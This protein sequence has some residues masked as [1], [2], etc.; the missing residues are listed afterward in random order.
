VL[1]ELIRVLPTAVLVGVVP[2]YFWAKCLS[3]S[4]DHAERI[5]YSA[6]LSMTLVPTAALLQAH[7]FGTGVT[8]FI[9]AVSMAVVFA[10]GFAI[11]L[12]LGPASYADGP[13]FDPP[14][15]PPGTLAL[16][17]LLAA[18][19]VML[20]VRLGLVPEGRFV[21]LVA[22]LFAGIFALLVSRRP[23]AQQR[24]RSSSGIRWPLAC[25]AL[26]LAVFLTVLVRAYLGPVLHDWP[27]IRGGD[28]YS[29]A[30]MANLMMTEGTTE[31][32]LIYPPGFH[33]LTALVSRSSGLEPLRIFPVL[34]PALTVLPTL[35]CYV[36]ARRLWGRGHGVVAAFFSGVLLVGP[37]ASFAEARYPNLVSADFLIAMAAAALIGVYVSPGARP[38][39]L[40]AVLGSSVVLY[41]QVASLYLAL[42]LAVI[43]ALFLP[44]LLV[45]H[46]RGALALALSFSLL[47]FLAVL[48]AWST[49]D[50]PRLVS[51]LVGGSDTGAGGKAVTI[52][53]GSQEPLSLAHLMEMTSQPVLWFGVLGALLVTGDLLRGRVG[54]QQA[55]AYLTL[56]LWAV[57]L[58]AGSRT[59]LSGFPQRFE[60]D[61]GIPLAVLATLSFVTVLRSLRTRE[62]TASLPAETVAILAATL[63]IVVVGSQAAEN[64]S[65]ADAPSNN[66][67]APEVAAA[68]EWLEDH[69]T[70][71]NIVVTPYLNDHVPGSAM[72]AMG[73]YTGLRSYTQKRLLSPR[74]LPPSGKESLLAARWVTD[75]PTGERTKSILETYDIRYVT[76]FKKYPGV[77]WRAF[78]NRPR[79]Y[80]K[81]FDNTYVVIFAPRG[82]SSDLRRRDRVFDVRRP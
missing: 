57:L 47:G 24:S 58:F 64:L 45:R 8:S 70:D 46:G 33:T 4:A 59:S 28:Q 67:I 61:L 65:D 6:A 1:S 68:G 12:W 66:V 74:A 26:L 7:L 34:A 50:L 51:G 62:A 53:I 31:R 27:F 36:L 11:Y 18:F 40:F 37:Y 63:A 81:V 55:L 14:P 75:H 77:R 21:L 73:G 30:V 76:L 13:I 15:A 42:L 52:A 60:R 39:L 43:A 79:L 69:N 38:G 19:G 72:L 49:Y 29:H 10:M 48:Y 22:L 2:G 44:Y 56:L 32:Y 82:I 5:A 80:R 35:A 23:L 54:R 17:P 78:E 16:V 3:S 71:G 20:G 25:S 41:H 9:T